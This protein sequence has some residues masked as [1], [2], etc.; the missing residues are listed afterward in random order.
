MRRIIYSVLIVAII[1]YGVVI[2]GRMPSP[3]E[4]AAGPASEKQIAA[5]L[6]P[7]APDLPENLAHVSA[8]FA[9]AVLF[10]DDLILTRFDSA[11]AKQLPCDEGMP[12]VMWFAADANV[13]N[14]ADAN[15]ASDERTANVELVT[16]G[17]ARPVWDGCDLE[18]VEITDSIRT[19]TVQLFLMR[20]A[21]RWGPRD[22]GQIYSKASYHVPLVGPLYGHD[23]ANWLARF[24][25][26]DSVRRARGKPILRA[27]K[28]MAGHFSPSD[29]PYP[30]YFNATCPEATTV[31]PATDHA[32]LEYFQPNIPVMFAVT[33]DWYSIYELT[34]MPGRSCIAPV[35]VNSDIQMTGRM[36]S[37]SDTESRPLYYPRTDTSYQKPLLLVRNVNG[38]RTGLLPESFTTQPIPGWNAGVLI[39]G[40][41]GEVMRV[42]ETKPASDELQTGYRLNA[43]FKGKTYPLWWSDALKQETWGVFWVGLLNGDELPDLVLRFTTQEKDYYGVE[44]I[45]HS[46][47]FMLSQTS[48][49]DAGPWIPIDTNTSSAECGGW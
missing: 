10:F 41:G 3:A 15:A 5:S 17:S 14:I 49:G 46:F 44:F 2:W 47:A 25:R 6:A 37:A 36:C 33:G 28:V 34:R 23:D 26:V 43:V 27:R 20:G 22:A 13:L 18:D 19:D 24:E 31:A 40:A 9:S 48:K 42:V 11:R 38:L 12:D 30:Q 39:Y 32:E 45:K 1:L 8:E 16:I 29:P 7:P 21:N 35:K 4:K